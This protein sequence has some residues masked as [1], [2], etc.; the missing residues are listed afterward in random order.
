MGHSPFRELI[1]TRRQRGG[2]LRGGGG[3]GGSDAGAKPSCSL[4]S[5]RRPGGGGNRACAAAAAAPAGGPEKPA[6]GRA[7]PP[8]PPHSPGGVETPV[9]VSPAHPAP[10]RL[11][12]LCGSD[13]THTTTATPSHAS[14]A[15]A[16][17]PGLRLLRPRGWPR[18]PASPGHPARATLPLLPQPPLPTPAGR[19]TR[20]SM[21][22][23]LA[24]ASASL[25]P[26]FL[27]RPLLPLCSSTSLHPHE[28]HFLLS[29]GCGKGTGPR[30]EKPGSFTS[31]VTLEKSFY[32]SS[33]PTPQDC[34]SA[35]KKMQTVGLSRIKLLHRN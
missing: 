34:L 35:K 28:R 2:G 8:P 26:P 15:P 12:H 20:L 4:H 9:P 3:A 7:P 29:G 13:P 14:P 17:R 5:L 6:P 32:F 16:R 33:L 21:R 11:A 23:S 18:P 22:S 10:T 27:T 25:T 30:A 19:A 24:G 31:C 1:P